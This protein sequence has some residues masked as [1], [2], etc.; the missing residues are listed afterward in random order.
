MAQSAPSHGVKRSRR[1]RIVRGTAIPESASADTVYDIARLENRDRAEMGWSDH[2]ADVITAF[3]GSMLFVFLHVAW[4]GAWIVL[5]AGI[6]GLPPFDAFPFGL[7]T[8]IVSLEAIFLATFVLISQNRQALRADRRS[9]VDLQVNVIAEQE[10]TK[11]VKLVSDLHEELSTKHTHD[12][13]LHEMMR[14]TAVEKLADAVE[15]AEE[16]SEA[17]TSAV[18]TES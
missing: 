4:F 16:R 13:E 11:L 6:F 2:L 1:P 17:P 8:M 7:L 15:S 3:S 5:N 9:K 10:I 18:D 12:D 14:P